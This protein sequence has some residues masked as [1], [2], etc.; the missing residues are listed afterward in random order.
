MTV[1]VNPVYKILSVDIG[2]VKPNPSNPRY[3]NEAKFQELVKS[4][5]RAPWMLKLRPIVVNKDMV[6]LGGNQ[7]FKAC[8]AL[9]EKRVWIIKADEITDEQQ[10]RFILRDNIDFG[11][12]DIQLLR[13]QYQEGELESLGILHIL[14]QEEAKPDDTVRPPPPIND[15]ATEP[16]FDVGDVEG[17]SKQFADNSIKQIVFTY[18]NDL[19]AETLKRLDAISKELDCS[20]NSEVLLRLINFYEICTGLSE[21]TQE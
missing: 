19:Y 17:H 14:H 3:I 7:R 12:F 11:K 1:T 13:H 6:I 15:G 18:E 21:E 20:D 9:G 5:K 2:S 8:Q 4:I 10:R 16:D